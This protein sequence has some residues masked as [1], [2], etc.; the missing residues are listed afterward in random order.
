[1]SGSL[2]LALIAVIV[3][4]QVGGALA[5]R[6][7]QPSVL[8]ELAVG[9]CLG[10][11]PLVGMHG[12]EFIASDHTIEALAQIGI[13]LLLF[14]VGLTTR[15]T[16]L[17]RVGPSA[18]LVAVAGVSASMFL[19]WLV[20]RWFLPGSH[21][22][23]P[24]F[25]GATLSATSVGISA[26][27]LRD[28]DRVATVEGQIILGA[29]VIDDVLGLLVLGVI[30][31]LMGGR[32]QPG[33]EE[34]IGLVTAKAGGFVLSALL[35]GRWL[36]PR[37]VRLAARLRGQGVIFPAA[38]ATCF[39]FA[40]AA[41][42][43]GLAPIVGAFAAGLMLQGCFDEIMPEGE[44]IQDSL[45]PLSSLLVPI[46]FLRMGLLVDLRDLV[47]GSAAFALALTVAAI[48]GKQACAAGVVIRGVDRITVGLGM[49]PRG[50]VQLIFAGI[51]SQLGVNGRPILGAGEFAGVVAVVLLTT[52]ITPPLLR[53]RL[54]RRDALARESSA[55]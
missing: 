19:G 41:G 55:T 12:F 50:E 36:A 39:T 5:D 30:V 52:V 28:L 27:L 14:E 33:I 18:F 45:L 23:V 8:G 24:L 49:I 51:G 1:M 43:A 20:G 17:L 35:L 9:I 13:L 10:A 11:L 3:A 6:V 38:L 21:P 32:E 22:Y 31:A 26:R 47:G 48:L 42:F 4:A 37:V 53:W 29:A 46:F 7:G 44:S 54:T 25:L 16:G 2:L 34:R 40:W 15:L